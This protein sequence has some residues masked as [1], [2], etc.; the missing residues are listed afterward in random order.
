[1]NRIR[2]HSNHLACCICQGPLGPLAAEYREQGVSIWNV[3]S[4]CHASACIYCGTRC[5][6]HEGELIDGAGTGDGGTL[7]CG[8]CVPGR[9]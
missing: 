5:L 7:S 3:C 6:D 1:M 9:N 2:N 4:K 8:T